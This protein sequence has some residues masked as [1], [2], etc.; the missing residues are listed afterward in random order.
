MTFD[1]FSFFAGWI[2]GLATLIV[3][4]LGWAGWRDFVKRRHLDDG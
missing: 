1:P 3:C 4:V 2:S